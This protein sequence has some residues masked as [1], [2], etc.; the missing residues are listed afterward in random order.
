MVMEPDRKDK[1]PA[2]AEVWD[3]AAVEKEKAKV[4]AGLKARGKAKVVDGDKEKDKDKAVDGI[5]RLFS[6]KEGNNAGWR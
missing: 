6:R 3:L 2:P 4:K 1:A 5:G